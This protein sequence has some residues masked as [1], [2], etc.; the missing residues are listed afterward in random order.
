MR[1]K[2]L[3]VDLDGVVRQWPKR[4]EQIEDKYGLRRGAIGQVAFAPQLLS[5][6][7]TGRIS[8]REWRERVAAQLALEFSRAAATSAVMNW[9]QTVGQV[10]WETLSILRQCDASLHRVLVTNATSRLEDDLKQLGL[11]QEFERVV[12]S[13][14]VGVAKPDRRIFEIALR[15]AGAEPAEALFVDDTPENVRAAEVLGMTGH[16]FST[17][18]NLRA[19]FR[20]LGVIG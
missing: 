3:L 7:V 6:S 5:L 11:A 18:D 10:N 15:Q 2:A 14:A 4:N 13:S 1:Y 20:Q 9:S 8:D 16:V 12:N 19:F 17:P